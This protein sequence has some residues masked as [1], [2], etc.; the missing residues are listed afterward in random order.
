MKKA[1]ILL[2]LLLAFASHSQSNELRSPKFTDYLMNEDIE[3][4]YMTNE[5]KVY[6]E[7]WIEYIEIYKRTNS[8][9]S[10]AVV[11]RKKKKR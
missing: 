3:S 7:T 6:L 5:E 4:E 1:L 10:T 9:H 2:T 11:I 8:M